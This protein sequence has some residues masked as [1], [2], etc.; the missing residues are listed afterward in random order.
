MTREMQLQRLSDR[1][2]KSCLSSVTG[3]AL[4][5]RL[6]LCQ[7]SIEQVCDYIR[8]LI[9]DRKLAP[10]PNNQHENKDVDQAQ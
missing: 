8:D 5:Y 6:S 2:I 10:S 3:L 7:L 4:H 9:V 1:T